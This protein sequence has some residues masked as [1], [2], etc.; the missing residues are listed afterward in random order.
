MAL[1]KDLKALEQ[2][3]ILKRTLFDM[4]Y[5]AV[6]YEIIPYSDMLK[7]VIRELGDWGVAHRAHVLGAE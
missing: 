5:I 1:S 2:H 6:E 4:A 3:A 7:N